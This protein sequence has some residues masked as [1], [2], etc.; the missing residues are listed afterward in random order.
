MTID[1]L[2]IGVHPDDVELSCAGTL[3]RH[4]D[5]GYTFGLLDLTRG[6]L[7]TRGTAEIRT[8]EAYAAAQK[9]GAKFRENLDLPDGFV[10][11]DK[12]TLLKIASVIRDFRPRI[13]LCNALSDRHPDHAR[14]A[15]IVAEAC[16][17]AG[18][19][20]VV[21]HNLAGEEQEAFRPDA[22][23]H[24]IQDRTRRPDFVVDITDYQDRKMEAIR[25]Y[26]SQFNDHQQSAYAEEAKT[27]ISGKDFMDYLEARARAL[28]REA[29]FDL[30][31]GFNVSRY[32]GVTD[33]FDLK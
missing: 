26:T 13:V 32:P 25:C 22:V 21:T 10:R 2:A 3:L 4:A 28:G 29:G 5:Q 11:P 30:A 20:K 16:F 15:E 33:L 19:R 24:Y 7:G 8:R 12:Q 18:L 9:L 14:S 17:I 31:E 23:Y 1:I 27:P 6:E